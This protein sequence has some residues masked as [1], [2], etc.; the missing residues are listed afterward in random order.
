MFDSYLIYLYTLYCI[1]RCSRDLPTDRH[2]RHWRTKISTGE[3]GP[4]AFRHQWRKCQKWQ[5]KVVSTKQDSV[6][7]LPLKLQWSLSSQH[8]TPSIAE[9]RPTQSLKQRP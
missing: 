5:V 4:H 8:A 6:G 2:F 7:I 3:T 1:R 9:P